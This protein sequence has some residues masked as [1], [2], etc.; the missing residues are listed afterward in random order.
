MARVGSRL[1]LREDD[2]CI[3]AVALS[4]GQAERGAAATEKNGGNKFSHG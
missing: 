2:G 3:V 1:E 4:L